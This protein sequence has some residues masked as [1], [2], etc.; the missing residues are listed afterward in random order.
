[1]NTVTNTCESQP[2]AVSQNTYNG[3]CDVIL[4]GQCQNYDGQEFLLRIKVPEVTLQGISTFWYHPQVT[5]VGEHRNNCII[6][7]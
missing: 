2:I 1:M 3:Q 4:W 7:P 6:Q 5:S